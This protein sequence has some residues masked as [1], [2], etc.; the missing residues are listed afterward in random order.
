MLTREKQFYKMILSI[1]LPIGIQN[2]I[3]FAV[4]MV[5]TM[6]LGSLGEIQL[7]AAAIAN[8]LFFIF[9]ILM[10]GLAGGTNVMVSQYWGKQDVKS[11]H[12][13]LAM[14]YRVCIII[15][16]LFIG[17]ALFFPVQFMSIFTTD[18]AVILEGSKYLQIVCVGYIFYAITNCTIMML[19]SVKTVKIAMVVYTASLI[20]N[21]FLNWVLIFGKLGAPTLGIQGAAIAT[22]IARITEF[23][24]IMTFMVFKENK[25]KLSVKHLLH[26]DHGIVNYYLKNC[27]PVMFNEL[28]WAIGSTVIAFIVGRMG[29]DVVAANSIST[30]ANQFVTVFIFGLSSATAVIIG[31]TIGEGKYEKAREYALTVTVVGLAMGLI[32]SGIVYLIRPYIVQC[33][34]V[35]EG[36]KQIAISIMGVTSFII[37]F[38][39]LANN[40]MMGILRGGGDAKFVLV[41]DIIFMWSVAIPLGLMAAFVWKLPLIVVFF[42]IRSDEILKSIVA[43]IRILSGKWVKDVTKQHQNTCDKN[44]VMD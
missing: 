8:N 38:Q 24:I 31:N 19:R 35:S 40:T 6:M 21:A 20:V 14:M 7:S 17:V 3:T 13:I 11:I 23:I 30:V 9:T 4:S 36:T 18:T 29:T 34:N 16:T 33:Y 1:S 10:F 26:I 25:I 37:I 42:I 43:I 28:I 41:N 44:F 32:A 39:A 12:K 5:D 22:V 2:L 15:T 27:M